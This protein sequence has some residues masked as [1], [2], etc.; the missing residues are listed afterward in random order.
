VDGFAEDAA[1]WLV[2]TGV[3]V[4]VTTLYAIGKWAS[5]ALDEDE[6]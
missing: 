2:L 5:Q 6:F 4:A 1:V 3:V